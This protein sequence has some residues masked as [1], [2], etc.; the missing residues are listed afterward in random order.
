M[1]SSL[2]SRSKRPRRR[3]GN[4][5]DS[6]MSMLTGGTRDVKPQFL[7]FAVAPTAID[8][9]SVVPVALPTL[10]N[11]LNGNKAQIVE[12]LKVYAQLPLVLLDDNTI[13]L[14]LGTKEYIGIVQSQQ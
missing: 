1:Q 7:S 3:N 14:S 6:E 11:F 8:T 4:S 2:S 5:R 9:M 12:I 10:K 13:I